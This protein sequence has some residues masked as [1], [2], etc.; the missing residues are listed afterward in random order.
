M[1]VAWPSTV[2]SALKKNQ[3]GCRYPLPVRGWSALAAVDLRSWLSEN[4][5]G[6]ACQSAVIRTYEYS[7]RRPT[8]RPIPHRSPTWRGR[9]GSRL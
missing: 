1:I 8:S 7:H 9:H 6:A 5:I 3:R 4:T 2:V